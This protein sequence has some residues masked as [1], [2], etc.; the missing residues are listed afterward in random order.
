MPN[1][2]PMPEPKVLLDGLAYV[3]SS[4][5]HDGRWWFAQRYWRDRRGRSRRQQ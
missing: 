2:S 3:E 4:R 1:S 5:W